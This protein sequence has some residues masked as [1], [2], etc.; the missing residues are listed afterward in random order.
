[1]I[2]EFVGPPGVGKTTIAT[3]MADMAPDVIDFPRRQLAALPTRR[4]Q[5]EKLRIG[6]RGL[7]TNSH[8]SLRDYTSIARSA[9]GSKATERFRIW[10]NWT[11][12]A[13]LYH[14]GTGQHDIRLFDQGLIQAYASV[15]LGRPTANKSLEEQLITS[16]DF[17]RYTIV[18]L[19]ADDEILHQRLGDRSGA[20]TRVAQNEYP[21][22]L[23]DHRKAITFAVDRIETVVNAADMEILHGRTDD[24]SP[25][26]LAASFLSDI[27]AKAAASA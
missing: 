15:L 3:E 11:V 20:G 1:M 18:C 4:R 21:Y 27:R 17:S 9:T 10:L 5:V 22:T 23:K 6:L 26:E 2:V 8:D 25:D 14:E 7:L 16:F 13:Q 12:I 19:D 24:S